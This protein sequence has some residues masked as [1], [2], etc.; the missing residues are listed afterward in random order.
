MSGEISG[1]E[2]KKIITLKMMCNWCTGKELCDLW[3]KFINNT[4]QYETDNYILKI[5]G[6]EMEMKDV[7]YILVVNSTSNY[8]VNNE[9]LKKT[10]F[11]KMEPDFM[12]EFWENIDKKLLKAKLVHGKKID[13]VNHSINEP[14]KFDNWN[15]LEWHL[16]KT[17][18]ELLESDYSLEKNKGNTISSIL[19]GKYFSEGHISR[20][21]FALYAQHFF[22]WDAYGYGSDKF[23]WLNYL[24][25]LQYKDDALIPYKYSFA[26][27]NNYINGYITEKLIDCILAET[28]CFYCGAPNVSQLIDSKAYIKL[29][30]RNNWSE[31]LLIIKKAINNNEWEKRLPYIK[32]EKKRIVNELNMFPRITKI[33][34]DS[35]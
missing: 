16:N 5:V 18:Q 24:G 20:I 35:L 23:H 19:S 17:K 12:D 7:D 2:K 27:E 21:N 6:E 32:L 26:C 10:I 8:I 30:L 25:S 31:S 4:Y 14:I 22:S 11:M 28:L 33:I 13:D 3:N 15:N 34:D 9:N 1:D 29:D